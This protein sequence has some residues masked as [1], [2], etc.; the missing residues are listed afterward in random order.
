MQLEQLQLPFDQTIVRDYIHNYEKVHAFYPYA[1]Y[2]Q[3]SFARRMAWLAAHPLPHRDAL[4]DGLYAFNKA[5]GNHERA[6]ENIERLRQPGTYA[7]V[8][9]QQ[10]GVL[11]GP[12]YTIHKAITTI[13]LAAEQEAKLGH[14]VIPVFWIAGED[15][16][17]EE[18]NHTYVQTRGAEV[19]KV[20]L[21]QESTSRTSIS[22]LPVASDT[23][24]ELVDAYFEEQIE[25]EFTAPIKE[26][27]SRFVSQSETLTDFFARTMAWLFGAHGL[28]LLDAALPFVR[29]LEAPVFAAVIEKNEEMSNAVVLQGEKLASLGYHRQVETDRQNAQFF[30]YRQG[31]RIG[32][33][34][35]SDGRFET[36]D[37]SET[38]TKEEL[39][40]LLEENPEQFSANVVT[41]PLM[42]EHLLPTLAF[43]GGPGE[44][45][46]WG[47]YAEAF[48]C[49]GYEMPPI[50]PRLSFSL[51]EGAVQKNMRKYE[52]HAADALLHLAD[53]RERFLR[54]QDTHRFAEKFDAV[55]EQIQK[56]YEPLVQE[57]AEIEKG[58]Q[59]LGGKNL[60]KILEQVT[61]YEQKT[62]AAFV[63]QHEAALRQFDRIALALFPL[64]KPQE[65]VYNI[66]GYLNKY[67][68]DWF[69]EF[70]S[71]PYDISPEH[72]VVSI[73]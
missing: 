33:T 50:V 16:D 28:V 34:R 12:L 58:L 57:A 56:L 51:L 40:H 17:Y 2:E 24:K 7:V 5:V 29:R 66:F 20:K 53:R 55:R 70:V 64:D 26:M 65:R 18:V 60:E 15:H 72:Y 67:G 37:G 59:T 42:Q 25:T 9:G 39:L 63:K 13:R 71:Y 49:M 48:R 35:L 62:Q 46:Y 45:A 10:A 19:K 22:H 4:A 68:M 21:D 38:Y 30:L 6:L 44:V 73:D 32:V 23:M 61:Y 43:V 27:L 8:S 54:E 14:A 31:E 1:P 41:R 36:K 11:T 47:L 3:E 69:N 52:L